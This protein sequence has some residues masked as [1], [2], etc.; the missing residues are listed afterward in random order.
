[1]PLQGLSTYGLHSHGC[2]GGGLCLSSCH[3][4]CCKDLHFAF[5]HCWPLGQ[6]WLGGWDA[7]TIGSSMVRNVLVN[8]CRTSYHLDALV[9]GI[10][11]FA[12]E[13]LRHHPSVSTI[14]M[15]ACS[16]NIKFQQS[17]I[18]KKQFIHLI[19]N[20]KQV[21]KQCIISGPLPFPCFGDIKFS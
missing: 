4:H 3:R 12:N 17:E 5:W 15:H 9:S 6:A 19:H 20:I 7:L 8:R 11:N 2:L 1:M 10:A 14:I 18:L 16:N 21:S 13:H